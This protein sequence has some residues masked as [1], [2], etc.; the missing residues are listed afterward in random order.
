MK[1]KWSDKELSEF[2]WSQG[3]Q[4]SNDLIFRVYSG[5]LLGSEKELVLH[6]GGNTSVKITVTNV[7][8]KQVEAV[9]VKA[10]GVDLA[11]ID[12]EQHTALDLRYLHQLRFLDELSDQAMVN[13]LNTHRLDSKAST[14]SIEALMHAFLSP[15][16]I[17]HTHADS[18]L[19]LSNRPDGADAVR[20]ALGDDVIVLDYVKPGFALAKAVADAF[21]ASPNSPGMVLM[22]HGLVTWGGR[23]RESYDKTISLVNKA[24]EY[25]AKEQKK[26]LNVK[27]STS[28]DTA[29]DRYE[30]IAPLLRGLLAVPSRDADRPYNNFVLRPL[31]D[32]NTLAL[33]GSDL[34]EEILLTPPLTSDHLIRTKPLPLWIDDPH[35]EDLDLLREQIAGGIDEYAKQYEAYF[36]RHSTRLAA[37]VN[38]FDSMPRVIFMQGLGGICAGQDGTVAAIVKD[39]T[40]QTLAVKA[41]ITGAA[42]Y[43]GLS[44]EH[45]F[46]MEYYS[47]QHAKLKPAADRPLSRSIALVTGAGGAIG[48]GIC[49]ELLNN[50]CHVA[51]TDLPGQHLDDLGHELEEKFG[52]MIITVPIDVT[53]PESIAAGFNC[54]VREWGGIDL[55]VANAGLAHVSSLAEMD[56]DVFRKVQKVNVE[57]TLHLLKHASAFFQLQGIGGDVVLVSTKNVFAPGANFGAYSATK[58][59]AHQ[60]AR[61]ASLELAPIGVRVNMV[62]PDAVFSHGARK[63]GLWAEVGP[64]RMRARGLDEKGLEQY[65]HNRNLLKAKV[66]AVHVARAVLFFATRQ[67]PTTGATIPVDGGLP[68]A[69]PR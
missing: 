12:S 27:M 46:D 11:T 28:V 21:D 47:L 40:V 50:G 65:Y 60:I 16:Y 14:A 58:A 6:G 19:S 39:I 54:I 2:V 26:I 13:E 64:D 48:T 22:K 66:T 49:E 37:G 7:L 25:L 5:R 55:I 18:I 41:R 33:V 68:D 56:V 67:T 57:G 52:G 44:E 35:Y 69:T 34:A 10:S 15:K 38:R 31:N 1:N 45:I 9:F 36:N 24:E 23:A 63:S 4:Y 29:N 3:E 30:K 17:D 42:A 53:D 8:G 61:I 32:E 59:A 51:A 43:E 62:S 20:D